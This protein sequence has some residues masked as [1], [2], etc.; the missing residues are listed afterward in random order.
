MR[1]LHVVA[2]LPPAGGGL[3]EFVPR[4]ALETARLGH[5]V[6]IATVAGPDDR[7]SVATEAAA[8]GGVHIERWAP[9]VPR[10]VFFSREMLRGLPALAR[11]VDL[12]HVHSNW[13]APVWCGCQAAAAKGKPLVMSPHGCLDPVRLAHS[14]WRKRVAGLCDRR[15]LRQASVIHA[16]SDAERGW[17]ECYVGGRPRIEVI[18]NGVDVQDAAPGAAK[19]AGRTRQVLSL[20][21]LHPLKGL[22][23][24]IDAWRIASQGLEKGDRWELLIAGP[25][26]QGTRA[27]LER[28]A[29]QGGLTNVR[30]MGPLY[31]EDKARALTRADLFVLPSRSENFGIVVAEALAAGVPTITTKGSPWEEIQ[32]SC[33]WWVDVAAEPLATTLRE[34]MRLGDAERA[35]MG[36]RGRVLVE[37]KFRWASVGRAM[38]GLYADVTG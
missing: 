9:S 30:F 33:G 28:Q 19:P 3:S 15:Y 7:L 11:A 36:A 27:R 1:V 14:A 16:T 4:L 31:G 5:E 10:T 24:L 25:D 6:T 22:D 13:T 34:A 18:P 21:R 8:A 17:I 12:V 38:V 32:D 35:D 26:E 20:G 37:A 23:L 2:G 29:R